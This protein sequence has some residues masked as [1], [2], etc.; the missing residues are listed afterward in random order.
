MF[1]CILETQFIMLR[2][3]EWMILRKNMLKM[4]SSTLMQFFHL[5]NL[6]I[7]S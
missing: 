5:E 7:E 4:L 6:C 3:L 1:W 2:D